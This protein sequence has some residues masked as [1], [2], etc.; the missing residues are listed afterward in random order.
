MN[1]SDFYAEAYN[2]R[3]FLDDFLPAWT[4]FDWYRDISAD[5]FELV[6][7]ANPDLLPVNLDNQRLSLGEYVL[8]SSPGQS[9]S[10]TDSMLPC[11]LSKNRRGIPCVYYHVRLTSPLSL[12]IDM[13]SGSFDCFLYLSTGVDLNAT[14]IASNDDRSALTTNSHISYDHL[15]AGDYIIECTMESAPL[16][17]DRP[18]FVLTIST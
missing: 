9:T 17:G 10:F 7:A 14:V 12:N 8:F 13:A 4:T 15:P 18:S 6:D 11:Q 1:D 2:I 5:G 3:N 16:P